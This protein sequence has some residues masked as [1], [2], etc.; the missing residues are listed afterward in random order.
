MHVPN[1]P[2]S[3]EPA[4]RRGQGIAGVEDGNPRR[5][6]RLGVPGRQEED[7]SGEIGGFSDADEEAE[8]DEAG[9]VLDESGGAG[10]LYMT[11]SVICR[12]PRP[13]S[14]GVGMYSLFPI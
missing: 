1:N 8:D 12:D 3:D 2:S 9:V 13:S 10:D 7:A 5:Q 4:E 6:L 14:A 11:K